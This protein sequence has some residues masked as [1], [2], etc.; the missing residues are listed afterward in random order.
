MIKLNARKDK[1]KRI[2]NSSTADLCCLIFTVFGNMISVVLTSENI[3]DLPCFPLKINKRRI[4]N[5]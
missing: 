3:F 4:V 5:V 1:L 2:S